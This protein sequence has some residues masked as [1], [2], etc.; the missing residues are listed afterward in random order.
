MAHP[1]GGGCF[2]CGW[3]GFWKEQWQL[4]STT[5]RGVKSPLMSWQAALSTISLCSQRKW[6]PRLHFHVTKGLVTIPSFPPGTCFWLQVPGHLSR[7]SSKGCAVNCLREFCR[8][9]NPGSKSHYAICITKSAGRQMRL[10]WHELGAASYSTGGTAP[11]SPLAARLWALW[12][13]GLS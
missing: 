4:S 13:Q 9:E 1:D 8:K 5:E 6:T 11:W 3:V 2:Y 12:N 7:D 10:C